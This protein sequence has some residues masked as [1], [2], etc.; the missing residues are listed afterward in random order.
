MDL[1]TYLEFQTYH[2]ELVWKLEIY[3]SNK[4]SAGHS[5]THGKDNEQVSVS[6]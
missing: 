6:L 5:S 4:L 3:F 1:F 2:K